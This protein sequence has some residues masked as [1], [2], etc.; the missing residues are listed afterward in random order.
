VAAYGDFETDKPMT[1]DVLSNPTEPYGASKVWGEALG[2]YY[3]KQ[4]GVEVVTL[5][6][7][8]IFGLGRAWRGSYNSGLMPTSDQ[9]HYMAR[10]EDAVRGKPITM[11]RDDSVADWTYAADAAQAS[12]LALSAEK[13]PHQLY[14]VCSESRPVGDFT[15][16]LRQL[17]PGVEI[18]SS[19][20]ELPGHAHT[21]MSNARIREDLGFD[22]KYS[23]E[24]GLEDYVRRVREYDKFT[25]RGDG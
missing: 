10:V 15:R 3:T 14:N 12:W 25:A 19:D 5:R 2:R 21:S 23:L 7:G 6:F 22:P 20:T 8:S 13:L 17:L 4:L 11:P 16:K 1:E 18:T 24:A 9:V